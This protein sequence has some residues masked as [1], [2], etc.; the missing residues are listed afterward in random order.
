VVDTTHSALI[1]GQAG[2][3]FRLG[4]LRVRPLL[5]SGVA[6]ITEAGSTQ[7]AFYL[8]PGFTLLVP[9]GPVFVGVDMNGLLIPSFARPCLETGCVNPPTSEVGFTV[10]GQLGV[11]F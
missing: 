10:H 2:Y 5:D 1:G 3:T 6:A 11:M 9:I 7:T 8:Q 4:V